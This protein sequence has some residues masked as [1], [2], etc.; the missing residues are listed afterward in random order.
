MKGAHESWPGF[1]G[2]SLQWAPARLTS[3]ALR[4]A[5]Y[6]PVVPRRAFATIRSFLLPLFTR[7]PTRE[8]LGSTHSPGPSGLYP[9]V[10]GRSG[11]SLHRTG[12]IVMIHRL[13]GRIPAVWVPLTSFSCRPRLRPGNDLFP[14]RPFFMRSAT[15]GWHPEGYLPL[16]KKNQSINPTIN[17]TMRMANKKNMIIVPDHILLLLCLLKGIYLTAV[18]CGASA[19]RPPTSRTA[20]PNLS[21]A[22]RARGR[23]QPARELTPGGP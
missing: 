5:Y 12:M 10:P 20:N 8:L 3:K 7:L 6:P 15:R 22:L 9:S 17:T 16:I 2:S 18:A 13:R 11:L 1:T 23:P 4:T 19:V 21:P 14:L